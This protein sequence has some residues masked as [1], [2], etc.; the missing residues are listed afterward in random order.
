MGKGTAAKTAEQHDKDQLG[1]Y[2]SGDDYET[3]LRQ[4]H[5]LRRSGVVLG[6]YAEDQML[7]KSDI[8]ARRASSQHMTFKARGRPRAAL[9]RATGARIAARSERESRGRALARDTLPP[10]PN[11]RR[12]DG[13]RRAGG[14]RVALAARAQSAPRLIQP[15]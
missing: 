7:R 9:G 2:P 15:H 6:V 5:E 1:G 10:P 13:P 3:I 11:A 12:D 8:C 4:H 14:D